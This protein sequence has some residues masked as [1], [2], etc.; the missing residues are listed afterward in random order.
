MDTHVSL[1]D[2]SIYEPKYKNEQVTRF[3]RGS[4]L[5]C[6]VTSIL[7][8]TVIASTLIIWKQKRDE[9]E[10]EEI[11]DQPREYQASLTTGRSDSE[12]FLACFD[13]VENVT[14]LT[15]PLSKQGD[16][17][18]EVLNFVRIYCCVSIIYSNTYFYM[19]K[20]PI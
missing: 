9:I 8:L 3:T 6:S 20:S 19:L 14:A 12:K 11:T 7:L 17:E 2:I 1:N 5:F 13:L 10:L 4:L 15:K 18:L 16:E